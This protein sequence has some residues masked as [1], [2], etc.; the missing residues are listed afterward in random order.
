MMQRTGHLAITEG[1]RY[2]QR[3]CFH[4][5]K[6][7][8]VQYAATEGQVAF[9]WGMCRMHSDESGIRFTCEGDSPE[10]LER[11]QNVID[12]HVRLFARKAPLAIRW[13]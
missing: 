11:V 6:K 8:S 2:L 12:E 7:V 3:L 13:S 5:S 1:S 10:A 9:P 4:F